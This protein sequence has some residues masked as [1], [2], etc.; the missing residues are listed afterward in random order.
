MFFIQMAGFPGSGKSTLALEIAIKTGCIVI[1]HD[2]TK[3]ALLKSFK[4]L[5]MDER[6][7]GKIAYDIDF[8]YVD[9]YLSQGRSV[10]LDSPCLYDDMIEKGTILSSKHGAD[11]KFI[12]CYLDDFTEINLRL[13]NRERMLSQ[14]PEVKSVEAFFSTLQNSKRPSHSSYIKVNSANKID[15]YLKKVLAFIYEEDN[16]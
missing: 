9:F 13:K 2:I 15:T 6:A 3:S 5:S 7:S 14:I 4:E 8:G 16:D 11:Y 1:D 12:E 10:I